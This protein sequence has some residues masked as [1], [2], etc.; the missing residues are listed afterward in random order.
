MLGTPVGSP[1]TCGHED[2]E[3]K[4]LLE[5]TRN[6][7]W[8]PYAQLNS[9]LAPIVTEATGKLSSV[10]ALITHEHSTCG[11]KQAKFFTQGN[12]LG[13]AHPGRP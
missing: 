11:R 10:K 13:V 8:A 1:S 6:P 3:K 7:I 2:T 12:S 4:L 5:P 9:R